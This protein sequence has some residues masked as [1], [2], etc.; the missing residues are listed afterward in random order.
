L[1]SEIDDEDAVGHGAGFMAVNAG[2][3]RYPIARPRTNA[4]FCWPPTPPRAAW[5]WVV[6]G[7]LVDEGRR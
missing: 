1:R 6:V 7:V 2:A 5:G 4:E 3:G